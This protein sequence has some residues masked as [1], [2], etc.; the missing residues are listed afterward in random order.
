MRWL[1]LGLVATLT[2]GC[3]SDSSSDG[4]NGTGASGGSAG[5]GGS[6]GSGGGSG[7]S[8]S[9][10]ADRVGGFSV[11][12]AVLM[13]DDNATG[14]TN[15]RYQIASD[16]TAFSYQAGFGADLDGDGYD[17]VSFL[18]TRSG[19][20]HLE[21]DG[22]ASRLESV[23]ELL[24]YAPISVSP[25]WLPIAGKVDGDD[26]DDVGTFDA[27]TGDVKLRNSS[28]GSDLD[29]SFAGSDGCL[30]VMGD[31]DG[32]GVDSFGRYRVASGE[33]E[34]TNDN[35]AFE[36]AFSIDGVTPSSSVLAVAGDFDGDGTDGVGA[37]DAASRRFRL[38]N[39]TESG[40]SDVTV[41]LPTGSIAWLPLVGRWKPPP[42]PEP[43]LGFDWPMATPASEGVDSGELDAAFATANEN[44]SIYSVL[45][46]RHGNLIA[47]QYFHGAD[48]SFASNV[49]SVSKSVL[50]ALV[51]IAVADGKL[52]GSATL[53]D[54]FPTLPQD[55]QAIALA[56]L[57]T[58]TAG[59]HWEE[60][61]S[62]SGQ[63]LQSADWSQFPLD[64]P[65]DTP[66]GTAYRYSTALTHVMSTILTNL[67]GGPLREYA[68]TELF[69]PL[70]ISV[71]RWD[72][73]PSGVSLGG[74]EMYFVPRDVAR[75]GELYLENGT[76]DG[77]AIVDEAAI[78]SSA[79][80]I[81]PPAAVDGTNG[82]GGWWWTRTFAGH[83]TFFAWGHGGTFIFVVRDLELVVV[84]T[85]NPDVD[86]A[87]TSANSQAVF[88]LFEDDILPAISG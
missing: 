15:R 28:D 29:L 51:A 56:H 61:G 68:K 82:Y 66:P 53:G 79:K 74:S 5:A 38:K 9:A 35:A 36:P 27:L 10:S 84:V 70:G 11:P 46:A 49:K 4:P 67:V 13:L 83:P 75:F 43:E 16:R 87:G 37:Y 81:L 25:R 31:W 63:W 50:S 76:L 85:S 41:D 33:F 12:L 44:T 60:N 55:K 20:F 77:K 23:E 58:M 52:V 57:L 48:R 26:K 78:A 6:G 7:G 45:V 19:V 14:A 1:C 39:V 72:R 54:F 69:D 30:P 2:I 22:A 40:P 88:D 32:D 21:Q 62:V 3:G 80:E 64:Q 17:S 71:V 47:E 24:P 8:T 18:D 59:L 34:L 65:L 86:G 42:T 73:D